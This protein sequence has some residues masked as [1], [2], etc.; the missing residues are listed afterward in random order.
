MTR[1]KNRLKVGST[2]DR[3]KHFAN[4]LLTALRLATWLRKFQDWTEFDPVS[5]CSLAY[6]SRHT[7]ELDEIQ[8]FLQGRDQLYAGPNAAGADPRQSPFWGV[9]HYIGRLAHHIR[10]PK[11]LV[12]DANSL[13][14]LLDQFSVEQVG[15]IQAVSAPEPDDQT[16]LQGILGRMVVQKHDEQRFQEL[17]AATNTLDHKFQ[18]MKRINTWYNEKSFKPRVHCEVRI[19]EHFY[20]KKLK[21]IRNDRYIACSKPACFCCQLYIRYHPADCVEPESHQKIYH[22]WGP[23]RLDKGSDDPG[24]TRQRDILNSMVRE[25]RKQAIEQIV[26]MAGPHPWHADSLT[27]ITSSAQQQPDALG[28]DSDG[29]FLFHRRPQ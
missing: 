19:L 16:T 29:K 11:E 15:T 12:E 4:H 1:C 5:V 9:R 25:I 13:G 24:Y 8:K 3:A 17:T 27:G 21:Y 6:E 2:Q 10:A 22:K 20:E 7:G 23:P 14:Y 26:Q 28:V 18:I